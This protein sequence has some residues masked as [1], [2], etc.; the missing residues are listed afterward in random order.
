MSTR[1]PRMSAVRALCAV[2]GVLGMASA[3]NIYEEPAS[4]QSLERTPDDFR[5]GLVLIHVR[6]C[7]MREGRP[8]DMTIDARRKGRAVAASQQLLAAPASGQRAKADFRR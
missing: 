2:M 1:L 6:T 3:P 8:R 4:G 7:P 5:S